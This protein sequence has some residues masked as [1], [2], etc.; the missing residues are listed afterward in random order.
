MLPVVG[1]CSPAS[2]DR[3][4]SV[5]YTARGIHRALFHIAGFPA[6]DVGPKFVTIVLL[7]QGSREAEQSDCPS[8]KQPIARDPSWRGLF[9]RNPGRWPAVVRGKGS[10]LARF[11]RPCCSASHPPDGAHHSP[12]PQRRDHPIIVTST[13]KNEALDRLTDGIAQLTRR[14]VARLASLHVSR[15][16]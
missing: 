3:V 6:F 13:R 9:T 8:R 7:C 14:R 11:A 4:S 16:A 15:Q 1:G 10:G 2:G 5:V 12:A